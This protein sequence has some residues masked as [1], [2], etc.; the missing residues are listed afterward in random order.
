MIKGL[1]LTS[2][3]KPSLIASVR[4]DN[5][6]LSSNHLASSLWYLLKPTSCYTYHLH[7]EPLT[8][9]YKGGTIGYVYIL[10]HSHLRGFT[11][12]YSYLLR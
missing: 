3:W 11:G 7:V 6:F 1:N 2:F 4:G 10:Q 8:P 12:I 5:S 9:A